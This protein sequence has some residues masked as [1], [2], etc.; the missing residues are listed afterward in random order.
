[1]EKHFG[2][3]IAQC[4]IDEEEDKVECIIDKEEEDEV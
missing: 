2:Q 4:I 1:M 3:V